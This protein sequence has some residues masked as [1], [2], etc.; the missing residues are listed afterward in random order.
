MHIQFDSIINLKTIFT[1]VQAKV[2]IMIL[3]RFYSNN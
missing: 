1:L 3:K 2:S